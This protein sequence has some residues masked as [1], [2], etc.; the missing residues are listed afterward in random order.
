MRRVALDWR[1]SKAEIRAWRRSAEIAAGELERT[2]LGRVDLDSFRVPDD[3]DQ[4]SGVAVDVGHHIGTTRM[5][6]S[7]D[8]GVVDPDCRVHEID[9]LYVA[10]SSVFPTGGFSNPTL[11]II[12]LAIRVADTIK[13]RLA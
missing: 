3:P 4:L 9:N 1:L 5:G 10:S 2:G 12:A 8:T 7:A 11:T 6:A 13:R